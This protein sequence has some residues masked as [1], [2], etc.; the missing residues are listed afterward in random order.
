ML[1]A[2]GKQVVCADKQGTLHVLD[3]ASGKALKTI[4]T[5][6]QGGITLLSLSPDATKAAAYGTD[7]SLEPLE[8]RGGSAA[9]PARRASSACALWRGRATARRSSPGEMDKV[10][11]LWSSP[12][13]GE[14]ASSL[15]RRNSE[16]AT[17]AITAIE[18]GTDLVIAAS[19]DGKVHVWNIPDAKPVA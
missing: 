11:R 13:R 2:D 6:N 3:A 10:V 5:G 4:P 1:S 12:R 16:G 14:R 9:S 18:T 19:A 15:S 17:G 7:G 8:P